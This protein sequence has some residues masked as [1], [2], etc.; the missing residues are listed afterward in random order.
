MQQ[1]TRF[2]E[3]AE[4]ETTHTYTP[5]IHP[6]AVYAPFHVR[7]VQAATKGLHDSFL[8]LQTASEWTILG[9][10]IIWRN[11]GRQLELGFGPV[12]DIRD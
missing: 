6:W 8:C 10:E 4:L 2:D 3:A 9:Y 1:T 7:A 12:F 5:S 11:V